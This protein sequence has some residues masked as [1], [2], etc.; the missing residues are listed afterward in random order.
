MFKKHLDYIKVAALTNFVLIRD[1]NAITYS[2]TTPCYANDL[3]C[4]KLID[5][6]LTLNKVPKIS[7]V[8]Y[9]TFGI[10]LFAI[11]NQLFYLRLTSTNDLLRSLLYTF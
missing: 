6:E 3:R 4:G 11:F 7:N 8:K 9:L 2:C 10:V 5:G 1:I